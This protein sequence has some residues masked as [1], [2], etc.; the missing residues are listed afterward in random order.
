MAAKPPIQKA[1]SK[2]GHQKRSWEKWL[3]LLAM[4][5]LA[6][7]IL[8]I[9]SAFTDAVVWSTPR[10][11]VLMGVFYILF[12]FVASNAIQKQWNLAAGWTLL[13]LAIWLG[14]NRQET[15]VKIIAAALLGISVSLIMRE[16]LRRR[17]R[18]LDAERR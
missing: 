9:I 1:S 17:R 15:V 14:L 3:L 5:P 16:F 11:Q 10:T 8:L 2:H 7:G 18:Y 12:S 13:G 6:V 4:V